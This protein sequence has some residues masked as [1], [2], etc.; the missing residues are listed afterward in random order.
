[1]STAGSRSLSR[2]DALKLVV[3]AAVLPFPPGETAAKARLIEYLKHP[4]V[5]P[6]HLRIRHLPPLVFIETGLYEKLR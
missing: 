4:V 2:R 3:A 1:M 5:W 6:P